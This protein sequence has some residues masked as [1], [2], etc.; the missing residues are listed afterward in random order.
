MQLFINNKEV[1]L[2]EELRPNLT[3][4]WLD[5]FNPSATKSDYSKTISIPDCI[6]NAGLFSGTSTD[7]NTWTLW[8]NGEVIQSGYLTVDNIKESRGLK[9]YEV[10]LYGELNNFFY[11]LKGDDEHPKKLSDLW[12][13]FKSGSGIYSKA[14]EKEKIIAWNV[15]TVYNGWADL[16]SGSWAGTGIRKSG[17]IYDTFVA[18]P[19]EID[20]DDFEYGKTL[21]A[22]SGS[23]FPTTSLDNPDAVAWEDKNGKKC[24][25]L[26]HKDVTT[27]DRGDYRTDMMPI[28]IRYR[29]IIKAC[30]DPD[31]NGGFTVNLDPTFFN[32]NNPYYNNLFLVVKQPEKE[33]DP[34]VS[35]T[36]QG[37]TAGISLDSNMSRVSGYGKVVEEGTT[38]WINSGTSITASAGLSQTRVN[39]NIQ[40]LFQPVQGYVQ[41]NDDYVDLINASYWVDIIDTKTGT[42]L[43]TITQ[44][45]GGYAKMDPVP[46]KVY[47]KLSWVKPG[48]NQFDPEE[49]CVMNESI[50][51]PGEYTQLTIKVTFSNPNKTMNIYHLQS[52]ELVG[53]GDSVSI[54]TVNSSIESYFTEGST[55]V[56]NSNYSIS[57]LTSEL[58]S[59]YQYLTWFT[60]MFNLRYYIDSATK[61]ITILQGN[62]W[63]QTSNVK[64][65]ST[66][67]DYDQEYVSKP[68]VID[69]KYL[70]FGLDYDENAVLKDLAK[71][72]D[73]FAKTILA[74]NLRYSSD[75]KEYVETGLKIGFTD[76]WNV[77]NSNWYRSPDYPLV[78][79]TENIRMDY[80]KG[81]PYFSGSIVSDTYS[82]SFGSNRTMQKNITTLNDINN[83]I[84]L[85][86]PYR[87]VSEGQ[88][89]EA[90]GFDVRTIS[91]TSQNMLVFADGPCFIQGRGD[92]IYDTASILDCPTR[93]FRTSQ[94]SV[95][96]FLSYDPYTKKELGYTNTVSEVS[97]T[98]MYT[99]FSDFIQRIY[100]N[101]ETVECYVVFEEVPDLRAL[102]YFENQY[103][104]LTKVEDYNYKDEPVKCTF[105]KYRI[106][107]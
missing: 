8:N 70:R 40:P 61:T 55:Y 32:D 28:G 17:S 14:D 37:F 58:G 107:V 92:M 63:V 45:I 26:E 35:I 71:D 27:V 22:L 73:L 15:D 82:S 94:M 93:S 19:A 29:D 88:E 105:V 31:N 81:T 34:N 76:S 1:Y 5:T 86:S 20:S 89:T 48:L 18:I 106:D 24:V 83:D 68:R 104:I 96:C 3:L 66:K 11:N 21:F 10:T 67:I 65:L 97:C 80:M 12:F 77:I 36:S 79:Q 56:F 46:G 44:N 23:L 16:W 52:G 9:F 41:N 60:K 64:D 87:T 90:A 7:S 47:Y 72:K 43:K 30:C 51:I 78:N 38:G 6:E 101:P 54:G 42:I 53:T 85:Y 4:Q 50:S 59:P 102:Y 2:E 62:N 33:Y 69:E 95:P 74:N 75:T 39:I 103:W 91:T 13:K 84:L 98:N 57:D 100:A 49:S 99:Y 25:V